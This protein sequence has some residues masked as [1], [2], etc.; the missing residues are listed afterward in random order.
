MSQ[1]EWNK[2]AQQAD[3]MASY[4]DFSGYKALG[5]TDAQINQILWNGQEKEKR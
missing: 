3:M 5:Y 4:G 2:A 1:D